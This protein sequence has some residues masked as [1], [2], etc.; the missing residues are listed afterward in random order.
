MDSLL[1]RLQNAYR[2]LYGQGV[3]HSKTEFGQK[4]GKSQTQLSDAFKDRQ[5]RLTLGLMKRVADAF[6]LYINKDYMLTGDGEVDAHIFP[7]ATTVEFRPHITDTYVTA[8]FMSGIGE[9][10]NVE[11]RVMNSNVPDYDFSIDVTGNSM[12]PEIQPGDTV[13][14]RKVTN[15]YEQVEGKLCVID[16]TEGGVIKVIVDDKGDSITLHS[17]NPDYRDYTIPKDEVYQIARV[18]GLSRQY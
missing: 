9:N 8:G 18:V 1:E 6:P 7:E 13:F 5:G 17:Y 14:C 16:S 11:L 15:R 3:I 12:L 10:G 2:F 4:I